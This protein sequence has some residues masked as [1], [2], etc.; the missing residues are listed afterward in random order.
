M[1]RPR[2][3]RLAPLADETTALALGTASPH[4]VLLAH[5]EGVLQARLAHRTVGTDLL[6]FRR[7]VLV[8]DG[9]ED[10]GI[11][12]AAAGLLTPGQI[13]GFSTSSPARDPGETVQPSVIRSLFP[14]DRAENPPRR[15]FRRRA[16]GSAGWPRS[17][18]RS[19]TP[20]DRQPSAEAVN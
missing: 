16:I 14:S 19:S 17:P 1:I 3:R 9:I 6:G 7:L 13:H 12:S 10:G 4:A 2:L 18:P 15:R 8:G 11:D 5:G 20:S